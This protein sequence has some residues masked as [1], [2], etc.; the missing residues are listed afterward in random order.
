M[1]DPER[2]RRIHDKTTG[3]CYHCD[4]KIAEPTTAGRAEEV[5]GR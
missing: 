2:L 3:Y 4:K 1:Q 5:Q